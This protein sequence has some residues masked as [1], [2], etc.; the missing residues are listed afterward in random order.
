[1]IQKTKKARL[2]KK[3][4]TVIV[5]LAIVFIGLNYFFSKNKHINLKELDTKFYVQAA[6]NASK[7]KLQL[8]W[9]YLA[10][11]DAVRYKNDF[12][13]INDKN[14][15]ANMFLQKNTSS[16]KIGNSNYKLV[17]LNAVL[18][19]LSFDSKQ[20]QKVYTYL[21]DLKYIGITKKS[22]NNESKRKFIN[23]LYPEAVKVYEQYHILP[24]VTI[25]QAILETGWGQSELCT[26]ANNLFGIKA[27]NSW[28]GKKIKMNTSE[29]YKQ[30]IVDEFR[31]YDNK[32][33]SVKDYGKFLYSNK[34]YKENGVFQSTNYL[35]Q[36]KVIEKAGYST[37]ENENGKQIYSEMLIDII[38]E[39]N[40]QLLDFQEEMKLS[41][42]LE[43]K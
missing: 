17:E 28:K 2:M 19:Q 11:I 38:Q 40:L 13:K 15:L 10:A 18:D 35:E 3:V 33:E 36:T 23:E 5:M 27:D 25:A 34:R 24:S 16:K 20:K 30:K 21:D 7:G 9:Q 41:K 6:D 4:L 43:S 39:Q 14:E 26:K 12:S 29:Y 8:N 37:V 1:M 32:V 31:A 22:L 42:N